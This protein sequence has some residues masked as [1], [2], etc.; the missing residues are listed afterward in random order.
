VAVAGAGG[1]GGREGLRARA[2]GAC[3]RPFHTASDEWSFLDMFD[4][5]FPW[6][7]NEDVSDGGHYGRHFKVGADNVDR[8]QIQVLLN[9][10]CPQTP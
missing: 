10:L 4:M 7:F 1:G 5:T 2:A 3:Q 9:G 8:M 6:H